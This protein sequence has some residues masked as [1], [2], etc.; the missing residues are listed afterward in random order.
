MAAP[1]SLERAERV[2]IQWHGFISGTGGKPAHLE[3]V[4]TR[5][6]D[7]RATSYVFS[8]DGGGFVIVATDDSAVPVLGYSAR[9]QAGESADNPTVEGWL[10]DYDQQIARATATK[11]DNT[12]TLN[13]WRRIREGNFGSY[14]SSRSAGPLLSTQWN[15]SQYYNAYCPTDSSAPW[16]AGGHAFAGCVATAMAQV[17]KYYNHPLNGNGSHSYNTQRYGTQSANFGATTYS[18]NQMPSQIGSSNYQY[19]ATLIFH[20]AVAVDMEF[21]PTGSLA[22][23][24]KVV[25]ALI[26]YFDYDDGVQFLQRN[27]YSGNWPALLVSELDNS[28]PILYSGSNGSSGHS[29]VID[30]YQNSSYYH[31]NF[32]WSGQYD[33]YYYLDDIT[34]GDHD[35]RQK[36]YATIGIVPNRCIIG[37]VV[38]ANGAPHPSNP[39]QICDPGSS[40]RGWTNLPYGRTCGS[41]SDTVCDNPDFCDGYG[42]CAGNHEP[43]STVCRQATHECDAVEYCDGAGYCPSDGL[44][45]AGSPC[46]SGED[47]ACDNPDTCS[48]AGICL[49]DHEADGASC[50]A[51]NDGCTAGDNCRSGVCR[52]GSNVPDG[53][54][55]D[56][57]D[58]CTSGDHCS[59]GTCRGTAYTCDDI[60][61]CTTDSCNGDGTCNHAAIPDGTSCADDGNDCSDDA[62]ISGVCTH[63][64]IP[65]GSSCHDG[66]ACTTDDAC[67][68]GQC[69]GR[70]P[71]DCNDDLDCTENACIDRDGF[72]IG[73][74]P[75]V[76]ISQT[77]I[78][79]GINGDDEEEGSFHFGFD[80]PTINGD[81]VS[82]FY[83]SSNG[84]I[85]LDWF[86]FQDY[87]YHNDCI[88][89]YASP[90]DFVAPYWDDLNCR[91]GDG[92][93]VVFQTFGQS[94]DRVVIVQW[95]NAQKYSL[96]TN[97]TLLT[98]QAA[99]YES[100]A[101][102]FRY[103][104]LLNVNGSSATVGIENWSGSRGVEYSCMTPSL[105]PG[106]SLRYDPTM[107]DHICD[108]QVLDQYCHID[109]ACWHG[110][111]TNPSNACQQCI[112]E[113]ASDAWSA[114]DTNA[115]DDGDPC[116]FD[117]RCAVGVCIGQTYQCALE[118]C[119]ESVVCDG[120]GGCTHTY[121]PY[122]VTCGDIP[123]D[124]EMDIC[125]GGGI[126]L[127]VMLGG[128]ESCEDGKSCTENDRC[129]NGE[130]YGELPSQCAD[131]FDCTEDSC[132]DTS[133]FSGIDNSFDDISGLGFDTGITSGDQVAG[134]FSLP[135]AFP[136]LDGAATSEFWVSAKGIISLAP[137]FE[138][139]GDPRCSNDPAAPDSY[140]APFWTDLD[141]PGDD[142][143][144]ILYWIGGALPARRLTVQWTNMVIPSE[145]S[146]RLSFQAVLFENG[147][148]EFHYADMPQ[149][150]EI[151]AAIG[152]RGVAGSI[153]ADY[154]CG[155]IALPLPDLLYAYFL[156]E[157]PMADGQ[158]LIDGI[159]RAEDNQNPENPCQECRPE[160]DPNCWTSEDDNPCNDGNLCT[161]RDRCI[162]GSCI[163]EDP[164]ICTP[165][166]QCHEPG[167]C[168]PNTGGCSNPEKPYSTACVADTEGCTVEDF[169]LGGICMPGPERDCSA[170]TD[171]CHAGACDD[172]TDTC[173]ATPLPDD[174][175]CDDGFYCMLGDACLDGV[176]TAENPRDCSALDDTCAAGTCDEELD[177]CIALPVEN[178][179]ACNDRV[180]CTVGDTCVDGLCKGE[181]PRDCSEFDTL[182]RIGR[183]DEAGDRCFGDP[184]PDGSLCDDASACTAN[185]GCRGGECVGTTVD[186]DDGN[187]C[188]E[189]ECDPRIGCWHSEVEDWTPCEL[190]GE[191][192][193]PS[194]CFGGLCETVPENDECF[195][196]IELKEH[197]DYRQRIDGYHSY[198]KVDKPC[199]EEP[200]SG[201]DMFFFVE[202][203]IGWLYEVQ[204]SPNTDV[205]VAIIL[206]SSCEEERNCMGSVNNYW[207]GPERLSDI[208]GV[209]GAIYIQVIVLELRDEKIENSFTVSISRRRD[210]SEVE[211]I[212]MGSDGDGSD[213]TEAVPGEPSDSGCR[214]IAGPSAA[215]LLAALLW[216]FIQARRR[217]GGLR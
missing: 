70:L 56:D 161:L 90:D 48:S 82:S 63:P 59:R 197:E 112:P 79:T 183:C 74:G 215:P 124:C 3:R 25:P 22:Y 152:I 9:G 165:L 75:F 26:D 167:D 186:C 29:F 207:F 147:A 175:P 17:M 128:G 116:T 50:D 30:G 142:A 181:Q 134:P 159:C 145:P 102:E 174:T 149:G 123:G 110:G 21:G 85:F 119:D 194:A 53:S 106:L 1:V 73:G 166:D 138:A 158:C 65:D 68:S 78:D 60:N 212:D 139:L 89:D 11:L 12:K 160:I 54:T 211:P 45:P 114:N 206:W 163:G 185:D 164:V 153:G 120:M 28:R 57:A 143:G 136:T 91:A 189:D 200:L 6:L 23:P 51:G 214:L 172:R 130:C 31:F 44:K 209:G 10:Y 192:S 81:S 107:G 122:G 148:V 162:D 109:S 35:F 117:D 58:P 132:S 72:Y 16:Y 156:C 108:I 115:C 19:V 126:C 179:T 40:Y 36:H 216:L 47:D 103:E 34:P 92:C 95:T 4:I 131:L 101:V 202:T 96:G 111:D 133:G 168:N 125:D 113:S 191:D 104:T 69:V 83:V 180:F 178:G 140:V 127:H 144:S 37:G 105:T 208:Q 88:P 187:A 176:C 97:D 201:A 87:T 24:D 190:P 217:R 150:E 100:G 94:P 42:S 67:T 195:G 14:K 137:L 135:F 99:L 182:C 170:L 38:Y 46:G 205:N 43:T 49:V 39:C 171:S 66:R 15:Q 129:F 84:L 151:E 121:K 169:C 93:S 210:T 71:D 52:A 177:R 41:S 196:V 55:C 61:E 193:N 199:H 198:W 33:G 32:G 62:C 18:W 204:V 157:H 188:M 5:S 8:F 155:P 173:Y 146:A 27:Y 20:C 98:F 203:E 154:A 141:F 7:D 213:D 2:A 118:L 13:Q 64:T 76:D 77:G 80:F 86:S 184:R